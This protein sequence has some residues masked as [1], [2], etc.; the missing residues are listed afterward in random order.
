MTELWFRFDIWVSKL[1]CLL[2]TS[3]SF[4]KYPQ[5]WQSFFQNFCINFVKND[6]ISE[7]DYINFRQ[8][9]GSISIFDV[10]QCWYSMFSAHSMSIQCIDGLCSTRYSI[11]FE[12]QTRIGNPCEYTGG[13]CSEPVISPNGY[14]TASG[15]SRWLLPVTAE[16]ISLVMSW[17]L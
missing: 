9:L 7:K 16:W 15:H 14:E 13:T 10:N 5:D 11:L 3:T 2:V 8:P 12:L 6:L 17:C 1:Y 4:L